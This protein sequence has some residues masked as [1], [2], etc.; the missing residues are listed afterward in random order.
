MEVDVCDTF[1]SLNMGQLNHVL[2]FN[3][4]ILD[5]VFAFDYHNFNSFETPHPIYNLG[6]HHKPI[7]FLYHSPSLSLNLSRLGADVSFLNFGRT[8]IDSFNNY[9]IDIDWESL[10]V[11]LYGNEQTESSTQ[12]L[13]VDLNGLFRDLEVV[14]LV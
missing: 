14:H 1:R 12:C 6:Q 3:K 13:R 4:R 7:E 10:F 11:G 8:N 5:L 9:L 2:N